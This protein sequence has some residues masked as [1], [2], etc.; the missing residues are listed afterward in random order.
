MWT[1]LRSVRH[2]LIVVYIRLFI[3]LFNHYDDKL[4][5][6]IQYVNYITET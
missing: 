4:A 5:E 6:H 1:V 2:F 3:V